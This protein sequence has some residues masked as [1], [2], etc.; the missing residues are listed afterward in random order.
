MQT[1]I[2]LQRIFNSLAYVCAVLG[3]YREA[4]RCHKKQFTVDQNVKDLGNV[5]YR[6]FDFRSTIDHYNLQLCLA[7]EMG[8][9]VG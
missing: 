2:L 1:Y 5:Y 8:E 7:N 6:V 3:D 9:E 4:L